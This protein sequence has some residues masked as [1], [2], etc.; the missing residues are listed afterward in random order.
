[1]YTFFLNDTAKG[2]WPICLIVRCSIYHNR[3][4]CWHLS[5]TLNDLFLSIM[6]VPNWSRLQEP[7]LIPESVC[8]LIYILNITLVKQW[9]YLNCVID[10]S[11]LT[12]AGCFMFYRC[13][14]Q[15]RMQRQK[16]SESTLQCRGINRPNR[17]IQDYSK[18]R[19][20]GPALWCRAC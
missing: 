20:R 2:S 9:S 4:K 1:M 14:G 17:H 12:T 15:S 13:Q 16:Y 6:V 10:S 3:E 5:C 7:I 11:S 8:W 18:R 19:P